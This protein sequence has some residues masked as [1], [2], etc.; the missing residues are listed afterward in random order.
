MASNYFTTLRKSYI[1]N[2]LLTTILSNVLVFGQPIHQMAVNLN[3]FDHDSDKV[4][5]FYSSSG[6]R[7][8]GASSPSHRFSALETEAVVGIKTKSERE[9][10]ADNFFTVEIPDD[11]DLA[12][13]GAILRYEVYGV[14][15]ALHTTK[16]I[17]NHS[18]VGGK[19]LEETDT[20]SVIEEHIP[21][22][23]LKNGKNEIYFNRRSNKAYQ[24]RIK[25]LQVELVTKADELI[26][27]SEKELTNYRGTL[28]FSGVVAD[29]SIEEIWIAGKVFKVRNRYVEGLLKQQ[30]P[31]I[32][33]LKV[34]YKDRDNQQQTTY[35]QVKYSK[36]APIALEVP[37]KSNEINRSTRSLKE[38]RT[39]IEFFPALSVKL[40]EEDI[41][42][43]LSNRKIEILGLE[44]KD[45]RIL[46]HEL[47]NITAGDYLGYRISKK[48]V[49]D[50]LPLELHLTYDEDKIPAGYSV[51]DIKTYFY[52]KEDRN[53]QAVYTDSID[54]EN[55][56]IISTVTQETDY[57]NGIIK[58]PENPETSSFVPTAMSD[59]KFANPATGVASI[60]SPSANNNG[61]VSAQ[62][63]IKIPQGRNGMQPSLQLTYN[64][65][66]G[67]SWMGMGW[68]LNTP[69]ISLNTKW[70]VPTFN[71]SKESELY[72]MNGEDLVL[73]VGSDYTSPQRNPNISRGTGDKQF[74]LR[75]EGSYLKITRKGSGTTNYYWVVEDKFGNK[76]YYGGIS[77]ASSSYTIK[78]DTG[79]IVH[80]ALAK[81]QDPYGN[82]ISYSYEKLDE[83][84]Q[85]VAYNSYGGF[86]LGTSFYLAEIEYTRK[87]SN[88]NYYYR[89]K[90]NRTAA[91]QRPD[92]I[93][94][95]RN[96]FVQITNKLLDEIKVEYISGQNTTPIRRYKFSYE[97][98]NFGKSLLNQIKEYDANGDLF[99]SNTLEY[100]DEVGSSAI[101]GGSKTW[102]GNKDEI[103]SP[104][105]TIATGGMSTFIPKGS[106][107]GA[108]TSQGFS[109][110]LRGGAGIGFKAT[111]VNTTIGGSFNY[112]ENTQEGRISF[113]DINGDGLSD[114]VVY[115]NGK[116]HYRPNLGEDEGFGSL[117]PIEGLS[118]LSKTESRTTGG[119]VDA[120]A[121]GL[122]GVGKS[123]SS[124]KSDTDFYFTDFNG[125]GLPDVVGSNRVRF[126]TTQPNADY[127]WRSFGTSPDESENPILAGSV[128]ASVI[129]GLDLETEE[130]LRAQFPQFDHVKAWRAPY[131]GV[132]SIGGANAVLRTD[133]DCGF[134]PSAAS[135]NNRFRLTIE[136]MKTDQVVNNIIQYG[137]LNNQGDTESFNVTRV[138]SK[139][140]LIFFRVHNRDY[141]CG[142]EVEWN[143]RVTYTRIDKDNDLQEVWSD[144]APGNDENLVD[145]NNKQ[146]K[147][148]DAKEDYLVTGGQWS[149][150]N[151]DTQASLNFNLSNS[152]FSANQFSDD[153]DF[154][155]TR[156]QIN[157]STGEAVGETRW[158]K[159]LMAS[160]GNF[161]ANSASNQF[162]V[163]LS[164]SY[165]YIFYFEVESDSN[166]SWED[167]EWFP[168]ATGNTSGTTTAPVNHRP[169]HDNVNQNQYWFHGDE[170]ANPIISAAINNDAQNPMYT[171]K[172]DMFSQSYI[173]FLDEFEDEEFPIEVNWVTKEK[174][175]GNIG[176]VLHKRTFYV[177]R[178][179]TSFGAV[180]GFMDENGSSV[181]SNTS[182]RE[183]SIA[184]E[185]AQ[186]I[187]TSGTIFSAFYVSN[188]EFAEDNPADITLDLYSGTSPALNPNDYPSFSSIT[189]SSPF[190][191]Y[192]PTFY[193]TPYRGWG[194]FLYNGALS[195]TYDED[196]NITGTDYFSGAIDP[197]VFKNPDEETDVD[198]LE[199]QID[200]QDPDNV[201]VEQSGLRYTVY[202]QEYDLQEQAYINT[203]TGIEFA[204]YRYNSN[205]QLTATVGRFG[206]ANIYNVWVDP[207][208]ITTSSN[209]Y[210]VG[211]KQRSK[212]KGKAKSG[213]IAGVVN[214]TFSEAKSDVL[215]QYIDLNGDRYPDLVTG[216]NIQYTNMQGGLQNGMIYSNNFRTGSESSDETVGATLSGMQPNS[217]EAANQ[218]ST[219]NQTRT[220]VSS[221]INHSEGESFNERLWVDMN[222]DGLTD[223]VHLTKTAITVNLNT[224]YGSFTN[225]MT[226][227]TGY[228]GDLLTS[229]R[230]NNS[231]GPSF[232][233]NASFGAGFGA[234]RSEANTGTTLLDVNG[235]GLPDLVRR[236][237]SSYK[238]YLN[239]GLG[240]VI[241][242][243]QKTFY[244]NSQ[245]EE[246]ISVS[247][248]IFGS[249]T[250]GFTIPLLFI[251]LKVTFSATAGG[252]A[253]F[254][255]TTAA[256]RDI[257]GDGL[258]DVLHKANGNGSI[259]ANL[260]RTGKTHLLKKVNLPLGGSWA[261]DYKRKGN[262][263]AMPQSKWVMSKLTTHD[264]FTGDSN[265]S[266]NET[267][268]TFDY[269]NGKYDR[270]DRSSYGFE[271]VITEQRDLD[272]NLFRY[273]IQKFHNQNYYLKGMLKES[274]SYNAG[275]ELLSKTRNFYNMLNPENPV[276]NSNVGLEEAY[277]QG[278]GELDRTR[279]FPALVKTISTNYEDG[280]MINSIKEFT[281]YD[282]TGNLIQYKD[283]GT[284]DADA[285]HTQISYE[286]TDFPGL[287][288]KIE[289]RRAQDNELLRQRIA[290]YNN[291]GSLQKITIKLNG[292][293]TNR[294]T[295]QYDAYGNINKIKQLD[296]VANGTAFYQEIKYDNQIHT[297]PTKFDDAFER[298][299]TAVYDYWF[300]VPV[301]VTDMNGHQM[302]TRIDDRGRVIEVTSP[303]EMNNT[304]G[305]DWTIRNQYEGENDV[306]SQVNGA[307]AN[308]YVFDA[309]GSFQASL[310]GSSQATDSEHHALTKHRV[311]GANN[312]ELLTVSMVDGLGSQ[313]Q[314][315]KS[316][317]TGGTM[318][319]LVSG[320]QKKDEFGRVIAQYL[321]TNQSSYGT[322]TSNLSYYSGSLTSPVTIDYDI[323]DRKKKMVQ[324]DG[325]LTKFD[326]YVEND[327]L[328]T[329]M[330][331]NSDGL[332]QTNDSYTDARGR[333]TKTVQNGSVTTQFKYNT[334]NELIEVTNTNGYKTKYTYDLAGR[335]IQE[336]HPDRGV[337]RFTYN[338][339]G[340]MTKKVT[341]NLMQQGTTGEIEYEYHYHRL[342][343]IQYPNS[344]NDVEYVYGDNSNPGVNGIGRL[345]MQKDASGMQWFEYGSLGELTLNGRAIAVAG[346]MSY[347]FKTQW[348]YDSWNRIRSI[349]YP[350]QE[351]VNYHYDGAGQLRSITNT[352]PN[353]NPNN[354]I[355]D[356]T[357]T[358]YGERESITYGNGTKTLYQDY[359]SRRRLKK[360]THD[361][362]QTIQ[363]NYTYDSY[364]NITKLT[365]NTGLPTNG[366]LAGPVTHTYKYDNFNRLT[367][368]DGF[369]V[370]PNDQPSDL[371]KQEYTLKME[372]DDAHNILGKRQ[373]HIQGQ[374]N[375]ASEVLGS[376][377]ETMLRTDYELVYE[378]YATGQLSAGG[379]SYVQPHA[380]RTI[381]EYP[382]DFG[383]NQEDPRIKKQLLE[384]DAD[385]NL[386]TLKQEVT[387]P[388]QPLGYSEVTLRKNLWDEEDRLRAVDLDPEAPA[389]QP[390]VAAYTYDANGDR[391][392]RYLPGR[393]DAY[394]SAKAAGS[395]RRLESILYPSPLL[396]VKTLPFL[397]GPG[398]REPITTYTKHYYIGSERISS[399]LGSLDN[400]DLGVLCKTNEPPAYLDPQGG[401]S[402]VI[403]D[404]DNKVGEA[405]QALIATYASFE[406]ELQLDS[407]FL[408]KGKVLGCKLFHNKNDYDAYW[409]H[410]DHLGSSSYITNLAGE[411]TQ[412]MEYLPF[413]ETLVE[414]HLNSY[415]SPYKFN[416]K[417]LDEE[418]DNYY[419]GA[420]YYNPKW[421]VWLSTDPMAEEFPGWS[422]YAYVHNNPINMIDPDGRSADWVDNGDGTWTAEA[423]DSAYSL[424]KDAGIS[425]EEANSI[426]ES[427]LGDNYIRESDGMLMSDVEIGDNVYVGNNNDNC[428][429]CNNESISTTSLSQVNQSSWN[430][431]PTQIITTDQD[432]VSFS[433]GGSGNLPGIDN[434]ITQTTGSTMK[435]DAGGW[436]G[437]LFSVASRVP[438]P[439][440]SDVHK[441]DGF[442]SSDPFWIIN[443]ASDN[444]IGNKVWS[445]NVIWLQ[446]T[447]TLFKADSIKNANLRDAS[448]RQKGFKSFTIDSTKIGTQ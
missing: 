82:Y 315:K 183:F 243:Q 104:L 355:T 254:N 401:S 345:I 351:I 340:N 419:Y 137:Y 41:D 258:P 190:L 382:T 296:N 121:M 210:F 66:G 402:M 268:T 231:V 102:D 139:G 173:N 370:G 371:L 192:T 307:S 118:R 18:A 168:T 295:F 290:L 185:K 100:Y 5:H 224:G 320:Y 265:L 212:S 71:G 427:Q 366:A 217:T 328:V 281:A 11:I 37:F 79:H 169:Y 375:S 182:Y 336:F 25:G 260:N 130:E 293:Q 273:T 138:V 244:G 226:W 211:L 80:W 76:S 326:Y 44:Y 19:L 175:S 301:L 92:P 184:K 344:A 245:L 396:T 413:G 306:A 198:E 149:P 327:K 84:S 223:K 354:V 272:E 39:K 424:A 54:M 159:T 324:P 322:S 436:F 228:S 177:Q 235:D 188:T 429:T 225:D 160:T 374:V 87:T 33:E 341:A 426:V 30:P 383:G 108:S 72:S 60:A 443:Y 321:P 447:T 117:I 94:T 52:N 278:T 61:S 109:A 381:T 42:A 282:D 227:G 12:D 9:N 105:H 313:I 363:K 303:K 405:G 167:I 32:R 196:D 7:T 96:G 346:K 252:L 56:T 166:V 358:P 89:V 38:L 219:G 289:V 283:W 75:K 46:P 69:A 250:A 124:T 421:S 158:Q 442:N 1:T 274:A 206:E 99:Y 367:E 65:E 51:K 446:S 132:V 134:P 115:K 241:E 110:G 309:H 440:K 418:T 170:L 91:Q 59:I 146:I 417:E 43:M 415:N 107:L 298:S 234:S 302:R 3:Y 430:N 230:E 133:N 186:E 114:K 119:G 6:G 200:E 316:H 437:N 269:E 155:I 310:P 147:R 209:T 393:M 284:G 163:G 342:T 21:S 111:S 95:A 93:V 34:T 256:V 151:G 435:L 277:Q 221:G 398:R 20:W 294:I 103:S 70:G 266:P 127:T 353:V 377:A 362:N 197:T 218:K 199:Q 135:T 178:I 411:I 397:N 213:N 125:D 131:D 409:Y 208:T 311:D 255:E 373:T 35:W 128:D 45:F 215:N 22:A 297:Y 24:Y 129:Q 141:G 410:P 232:N 347:W 400:K 239:T 387:D 439:R 259:D 242:G 106:A 238:Y 15:S 412:H 220:N 448:K 395:N 101:I 85:N 142:G 48:G 193:G 312:G 389:N 368:A 380:P 112:S 329:H 113:I 445:Q 379:E 90:F 36:N 16:S 414:E 441:Q 287:P 88:D 28:Y 157:P 143:P 78:D 331:S 333:Q 81:K 365:T 350:D 191:S 248:N 349:T 47:E 58:V 14:N 337:T 148:Y 180:Y 27:P 194:Q 64:S 356:I 300:G 385:G 165:E 152:N 203:N 271:T 240:F 8:A 171:I 50:S 156:V 202:G 438:N 360:L 339:I 286:D 323:K 4:T 77:S 390:E 406:K 416:A 144:Q 285:Y 291:Q 73:K 98:S 434:T 325:F 207:A 388:E 386:T 357:Y 62:F 55:H 335:R 343:N 332:N 384:Y 308:T 204:H 279:L 299:S 29:E 444:G 10:P 237:G 172:H 369:Y 420:R 222:G 251:V 280:G 425:M 195:I 408:Y 120:N 126:N 372:Y 359:D 49:S 179:Q 68:N 399:A 174:L 257:N 422:P 352:L 261:V 319:W 162:T 236:Q 276:V 23:Q 116:V 304:N 201:E 2:T 428:G 150:G 391:I 97:T 136:H 154:V 205:N 140:D 292:S 74:F 264:G 229:E 189:L 423:G 40:Q 153:V 67:N 17:N 216:S 305:E 317:Y 176:K 246:S 26:V 270:R 403:V 432:G 364:S 164:S 338:K 181:S 83:N 378:D 13:Y 253:S 262:T 394:Y 53:W 214:G 145:E 247:G 161:T 86:V 123:T 407:P 249:A 348:E 314:L 275:G 392:I 187:Y 361:L 31:H 233:F 433:D 288:T 376:S 330:L 334:V 63:P 404:L 57:I 122:I 267:L 318:V 431:D 263:Y